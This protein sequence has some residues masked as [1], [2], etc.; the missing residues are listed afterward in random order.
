MQLDWLAN[1]NYIRSGNNADGVNVWICRDFSARLDV[2]V[3]AELVLEATGDL[4]GDNF[5]ELS[6]AIRDDNGNFV[7]ASI[8]TIR[9]PD[10]RSR[11]AWYEARVLA[12]LEVGLNIDP[13]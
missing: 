8:G 9:T 5:V 1:H 10:L 4:E 7:Q 13:G 3:R 12:M 6:A 11:L 2:L